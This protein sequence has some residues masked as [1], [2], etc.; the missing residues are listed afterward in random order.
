MK[1][2]NFRKLLKEQ[3]TKLKLNGAGAR[4]TKEGIIVEVGVNNNP[5]V[6]KTFFTIAKNFLVQEGLKIDEIHQSKTNKTIYSKFVLNEAAYLQK[7]DEKEDEIISQ[8]ETDEE[9]AEVVGAYDNLSD[10]E[11]ASA[12]L[13]VDGVMTSKHDLPDDEENI[14]LV[15]AD[16]IDELE[17]SIVDEEEEAEVKKIDVN[18]HGGEG[19]ISERRRVNRRRSLL[20][21]G[22]RSSERRPFH[23]GR[24]MKEAKEGEAVEA[25]RR[26][27]LNAA[28]NAKNE[29]DAPE[30]F[31]AYFTP[32]GT[33]ETSASDFFTARKARREPGVKQWVDGSD[34]II[35]GYIARE[36]ALGGAGT[37]S[38]DWEEPVVFEKE[39]E[40]NPYNPFHGGRRRRVNEGIENM[41]HGSPVTYSGSK[42][43]V[44]LTGFS[45]SAWKEDDVVDQTAEKKVAFLERKYPQISVIDWQYVNHEYDG[46][47]VYHTIQVTFTIEGDSNK[48][49]QKLDRLG[50]LYN[51]EPK[52]M[53][54]SG[55]DR[56]FLSRRAQ[57]RKRYPVNYYEEF[58]SLTPEQEDEVW[59][60]IMEYVDELGM[61][62]NEIDA[63]MISHDLGLI[64]YED[65]I[66]EIIDSMTEN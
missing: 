50:D 16:D 43:Y 14:S 33:I 7:D 46:G 29:Y 4:L 48:V 57:I 13:D 25:V 6:A 45:L 51:V 47:H 22:D 32:S 8:V 9:G 52:T 39:I 2:E 31:L 65:D 35:V 24:M 53:N 3:S 49:I 17:S 62:I 58:S 41:L 21:E 11:Y 56:H 61:D 38:F 37:Q 44:G 26:A 10:E 66:Q 28:K 20:R 59:E 15:L 18:A 19:P 1:V 40:T 23:G 42:Q 5:Q 12:V 60:T 27:L 36:N 64:G 63:E 54:E 30:V 34:R 55:R